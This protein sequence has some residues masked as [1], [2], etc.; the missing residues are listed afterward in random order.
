MDRGF[1][2]SG[3]R[4]GGII[5]LSFI[6]ENEQDA[7]EFDV[8]RLTGRTLGEFF[9]MGAGGVVAL[10]HILKFLDIDSKTMQ[11]RGMDLENWGTPLHTEA[12]LADLFDAVSILNRNLVAA[13]SK[14]RPK[15][16]KPYPRPWAKGHTIG[17]DPIPVKDFWSWWESN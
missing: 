11:R 15:N 7:F 13:H 14:H 9:D 16:P 17:K 10:A 3:S 4:S 12:M 1:L 6:L 5:A 2:K 8:L